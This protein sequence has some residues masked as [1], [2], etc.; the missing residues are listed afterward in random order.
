MWRG[1]AIGVAFWGIEG[2]NVLLILHEWSTEFEILCLPDCV[3]GVEVQAVVDGNGNNKGKLCAI[4]LDQENILRVFTTWRDRY[5]SG[6][7]GEWVLQQS[8]RLA[9]IK[10]ILVA[11]PQKLSR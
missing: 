4:C 9:A 6:E 11:I 3:R 10:G 5:G 8:L 7:W 2:D 1:R